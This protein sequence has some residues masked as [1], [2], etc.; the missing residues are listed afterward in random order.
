MFRSPMRWTSARTLLSSRA[1]QATVLI[2]VFG[3]LILFN[4]FIAGVLSFEFLTTGT[5]D[6]QS[7]GGG[8]AAWKLRLI[9]F[10]LLAIASA[11]LLYSVSCPSAIKRNP[12]E[13]ALI[14]QA[15]SV[16]SP[17]MIREICMEADL[18]QAYEDIYFKVKGAKNEFQINRYKDERRDLLREAYFKLDLSRPL[19]LRTSLGLAV[20]GVLMLLI[21]SAI[22]VIDVALATFG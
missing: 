12:D 6:P 20:T 7:Q 19:V 4:D 3:Y 15:E 21:P 1:A 8:M 2:P 14:Q 5:I 9:F 17:Q 22:L 18:S 16:M 10:G 11:R 13:L